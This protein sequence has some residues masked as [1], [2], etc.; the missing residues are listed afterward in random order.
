MSEKK[1]KRYALLGTLLFAIVLLLILLFVTIHS[2]I[3]PKID[4]AVELDFLA[5]QG[6]FEPVPARLALGVEAV[7]TDAPSAAVPAA[8]ALQHTET[9]ANED[10]ITQ[11][12]E[13][14]VALARKQQQQAEDA[15]RIAGTVAGAFTSPTGSGSGQGTA[16]VQ[17]GSPQGSPDGSATGVLGGSSALKGR[18]GGSQI[19]N[20]KYNESGRVAVD[21]IVDASGKVT[22]AEISL[23][24]TTTNSP[25][26]RRIAKEAASRAKFS[27]QQGA[28][29]ETGTITYIFNLN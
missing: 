21:I 19:P 9:T 29:L 20:E 27:P 1:I 16:A 10:L 25:T 3:P 7:L 18:F 15:A 2:V 17:G 12:H 5:E 8:P 23:S 28:K 4:K 26:L 24:G 22:N 11:N 13:E 6:L 14:T